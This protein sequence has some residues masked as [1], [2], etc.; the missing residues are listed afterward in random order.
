MATVSESRK[1]CTVNPLKMSQPLGACFAFMGM[2]N[3]MPMMHGSQGCTSFGLVL[4]VRHFKEAIPLQT[5]AMNEVSTIL[6][7]LENI[8]QAVLN[9]KKRANP[10]FIA[11]A[12]TGLT[13][14]K[15]DDVDGYLKLIHR[16]H[17]ETLAGTKIVY[18]STPDYVGAFEDGWAKAVTCVVDAF[19]VPS[20]E[21]DTRQ[22]NIL[23]GCHLTS[24][25]IDELRE[26]IASFGLNAIVLPDISGSL[27]G[28][29]PENF[30]P[31]TLGGTTLDQMQRMGAS[32]ATLAI[33]S[34][35]TAAAVALE[36]RTGVP[37]RVFERVTGL[38]AVDALMHYLSELSGQP[39]IAKYR[40]QRGQLQDAMLDAHFWVGSRKFAI[41]AEPD[42]LAALAWTAHEMGGEV[43][44]AVTTTH[45]P[46]LAGLPCTEVLIGDLEDLELRAKAH[47]CE[48]LLTHSHGRQAAERLAI[49]LLRTGVPMFDRLGAAHVLMAGYRGTRELITLWANTLLEAEH[50][51]QPED[52][53]LPAESL[54]AAKASAPASSRCE[55]SACAC[56]DST[57]FEQSETHLPQEFQP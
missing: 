33:G 1:A 36:D 22:I 18:V 23:P 38:G 27:D 19:A 42:L 40:R 56:T 14:T 25:D 5:T 8:E 28:H 6:G 31:T 48:I 57:P 43:L 15:G 45:S 30:T 46:V 39:V 54:A 41:G 13:E 49:P 21:K 11:I 32:V 29:I 17:G 50:Q 37:Y 12:S 35:M 55:S 3:C 7:G 52:W 2:D 44:A 51:A 9:I 4:L 16:K 20:E 47:G 53:P 24:A 26:I 34:H 10:S